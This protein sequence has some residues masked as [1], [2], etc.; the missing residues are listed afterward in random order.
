[1][2][3]NGNTVSKSARIGNKFNVTKPPNK[4]V[5]PTTLKGT[6]VRLAA[7]KHGEVGPKLNS[8]VNRKLNPVS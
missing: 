3:V 6:S 5:L 7:G 2:G 4:D 8:P 1:M